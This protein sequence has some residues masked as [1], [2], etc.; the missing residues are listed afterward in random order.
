LFKT[1]V[2][3]FCGLGNDYARKNRDQEVSDR[4]ERLSFADRRRWNINV[5]ATFGDLF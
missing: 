4:G 1:F 3:D 2:F 5:G